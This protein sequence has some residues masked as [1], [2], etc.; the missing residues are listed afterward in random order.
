MTEQEKKD[1]LEGKKVWEY[2]GESYVKRTTRKD[3]TV[4]ETII[5][6]TVSST[7]M[8]EVDD[9]FKLSSGTQMEAIYA[10]HANKLKAL[11]NLSRK[12]NINTPPPQV[13]KEA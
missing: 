6:R 12:E 10:T 2:T 3:G 7:K 9:A 4:K 13:N 1:Y 5:P 11:G 8:A